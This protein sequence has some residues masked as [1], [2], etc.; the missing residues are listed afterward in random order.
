MKRFRFLMVMLLLSAVT[1]MEAQ[2][3]DSVELET[4][5][6]YTSLEEALKEPYK[7]YRLH[8][9]K[10]KLE[11][12]PEEIFQ[13]SNLQDLDLSKNKLEELP[14]SLGKLRKL[15]VLNVSSNNLEVFPKSLGDLTNL[16]KLFANKN[17]LISL[18]AQIG[19][20][21]QLRLLDLWS[22]EIAYFPEDMKHMKSLRK[23]DL[24]NILIN[25]EQQKKL[26]EWLPNTKIY[27]DP[28]CKCTGGGGQQ[29]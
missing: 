16:K 2:L 6:I 11:K 25:D 10:K 24:R 12:F 19:N 8:L 1:R 27:M 4:A 21:T 13:F 29:N 17:K 26:R 3:L 9:N 23:L 18:P 28:D 14:D 15:Q 22:N 7:V 5:Y 20:L